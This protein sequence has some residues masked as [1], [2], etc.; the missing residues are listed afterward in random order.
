[1]FK[2][3]RNEAKVTFSMKLDSPLCIRSGS[4]NGID[5]TLPDMQCIRTFK[6]GRNTVF[7]PGS[8]IKGV[9]RSRCEKIIR[10]LGGQACNVVNRENACGDNS[11]ES[12]NGDEVYSKMCSACKMFGS[13]SI[14]GRI[15]FKD[16]YPIGDVKIGLR[17]GVGIDRITGAAQKSAKYDFEVVEDATFEVV[18][19]LTNYELYQLKLLLFAIK[20][21][22]DGYV[23][24]GS[25]STRGNGKM[26]IE[27][28]NI[29]FRDYRQ[30]L[31][32]LMGYNKSDL[33]DNLEYKKS[34]YF[35]KANF[36]NENAKSED[37]TSNNSIDAAFKILDNVNVENALLRG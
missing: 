27:N 28:L 3:L 1:M 5:P 26:K 18:I 35:Y 36:P 7:I 10:F 21:I 15:K 32:R 34:L 12:L 11:H 4:E 13:T 19:T 24:F 37:N 22:D 2:D 6:D 8:S 29:E 17:D 9:I 23:S 20:D 30:N 14:G 33:G 25:A 16:A 31:S